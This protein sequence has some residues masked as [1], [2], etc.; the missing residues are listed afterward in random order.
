MRLALRALLLV[1]SRGRAYPRHPISSPS[2][3]PGKIIKA[4]RIT[5]VISDISTL[6]AGP[7]RRVFKITMPPTMTAGPRNT[8]KYQ[9]GSTRQIRSRPSSLRKD[10]LP[11]T[12]GRDVG[13]EE[14]QDQ[15][16]GFGD[17]LPK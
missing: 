7:P 9:R 5:A 11:K 14:D 2:A 1:C 3:L 8:T 6:M 16:L 15:A 13:G 17:G 4:S 10:P 12:I